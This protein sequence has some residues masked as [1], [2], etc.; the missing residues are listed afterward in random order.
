MPHIL[1]LIYASR[2]TGP[3]DAAVLEALMSDSR[4]RN[5][6]AGI[7]GIL[8]AGRGSF[9]Q[10]LEGPETGV[11]S[12]YASILRDARHHHATLLSIGLVSSR[13]FPQWAIA[14]VEGEPLGGDFHARLVD[15]VLLDRD[16]SEPVKLLQS[17]LKS[18]RKAS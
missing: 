4:S 1:R 11:I 8:C 14:F 6:A 5:E 18:L 15:Q 9:V 17:T 10:A 12:L 13:A 7:T 16:P 3:V 2:A